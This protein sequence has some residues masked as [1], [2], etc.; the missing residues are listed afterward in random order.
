M[1]VLIADLGVPLPKLGPDVRERRRHF[2]GG[3]AVCFC[4]RIGH[5]HLRA[6]GQSRPLSVDDDWLMVFTNFKSQ[7]ATGRFAGH[8]PCNANANGLRQCFAKISKSRFH[9]RS[10]SFSTIMPDG[11]LESSR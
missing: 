2:D 10:F 7:D 4:A 3:E 5:T 1:Q 6:R 11:P 8:A 9:E